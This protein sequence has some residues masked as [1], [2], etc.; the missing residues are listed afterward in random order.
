MLHYSMCN[1]YGRPSSTEVL[2]HCLPVHFNKKVWRLLPKDD[3][4]L[5]PSKQTSGFI[6]VRQNLVT[7]T[8]G[9]SYAVGPI[10]GHRSMRFSAESPRPEWITGSHV[11]LIACVHETGHFVVGQPPIYEFKW[12][13][14]SDARLISLRTFTLLPYLAGSI[15]A[16]NP[17][18]MDAANFTPLFTAYLEEK[19]K[20]HPAYQTVKQK[21]EKELRKARSVLQMDDLV[22]VADFSDLSFRR[23]DAD[24]AEARLNKLRATMEDNACQHQADD[25]ISIHLEIWIAIKQKVH[26]IVLSILCILISKKDSAKG[27]TSTQNRYRD[28]MNGY[29]DGVLHHVRSSSRQEVPAPEEYLEARKLSSGCEPLYALVEYAYGLELSDAQIYEPP[30]MSLRAASTKIALLH[31][32]MISWQKEKKENVPHNY[33]NTLIKHRSLSETDAFTIMLDMVATEHSQL[34][35][36]LEELAT[37]KPVNHNE[38][39]IQGILRVPLANLHWSPGVTSSRLTKRMSQGTHIYLSRSFTKEKYAGPPRRGRLYNDH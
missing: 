2:N 38:M 4:N 35:D 28:A 11:I 13:T 21:S 36:S 14:S 30:I 29:C 26:T 27:R 8:P 24:A 5:T 10:L 6:Y 32:D 22:F 20:V 33:I 16:T 34:S 25:M 19:P 17:I 3:L 18:V 7:I 23:R 1:V 12:Q 15:I 39:Y 31:N 9:N 37:K